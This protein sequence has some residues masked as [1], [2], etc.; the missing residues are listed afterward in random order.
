VINKIVILA[1]GISSRMRE[2]A[3]I[4]DDKLKVYYEEA[5][6][7][8]K[9]MISL[10]KGN[11]PF[12]DYLLYNCK[13][14]G[15]NE[16]LIIIG[17]KDNSIPEYYG[18]KEKNNS[19][20]GLSISYAVQKIPSHRIKPWGTADAL[21]QGLLAMPE[22]KDKYFLVVNSDNLYSQKALYL[23]KD[24]DGDM[25]WIDYDRNGFE[26]EKSRVEKFAV[27]KKD[28]ESFLINII[29]KPNPEQVIDCTDNNGIVRVSMNCW[30]FQY[31]KIFPYLETCEEN[32]IRKEKEI[33]TAVLKL[34]GDFPRSMKGLPLCEHIPDLTKK[35]DILPVIEYLKSQF[36]N[37][38]W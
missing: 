29:E 3:A 5:D 14:V 13:K 6:N 24:Y 2:R 20:Q 37:L 27:T 10:G 18:Q 28:D 21:Y 4:E 25:A 19:F 15:L 36:D 11:R 1:G 7:K 17:E 30:R 9:S 12:L 26:F 34:V 23:L 31:N 38:E 35:E 8:S 22:W 32:P 33:P 16:V